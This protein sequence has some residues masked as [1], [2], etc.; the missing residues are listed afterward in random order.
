MPQVSKADQNK[1]RWSDDFE[2]SIFQKSFFSLLN[3]VL[4]VFPSAVLFFFWVERNCQAPQLSTYFDWPWVRL[5]TSVEVAAVWNFTLFLMFGFVHS[6]LAQR[7]IHSII[8]RI[9]PPQMIRTLYLCVTGGFL[10]GLM[11]M[12]QPTDEVIWRLPLREMGENVI[13]FFLF[14]GFMLPAGKLITRFGVLDFIGLRQ[15]GLKAGQ[16]KR[17]EGNEKLIVEGFY[18]WVRHPVYTLTLA[19]FVITPLMTLDRMLVFLAT[20]LYLCFGVPV[21]ERK[22]VRQFG[23][24]Y[25][26]YRRSTPAIVPAFRR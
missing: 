13:S 2:L 26:N 3:L 18:R 23:R 7:R 17:T 10:F 19:A 25:E 24:A 14:W 16:L 21:E 11:G 22:L 9:I 20:C 4:G 5:E 6:A 15:L 1:S 12:W 8:E